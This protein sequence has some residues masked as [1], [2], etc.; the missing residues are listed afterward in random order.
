M[1]ARVGRRPRPLDGILSLSK[2]RAASRRGGRQRRIEPIDDPD[3]SEHRLV[4]DQ[5]QQPRLVAEVEVGGRLIHDEHP[6]LKRDGFSYF[7]RLLCR[8]RQ[9]SCRHPHVEVYVEFRQ[10]FFRILVH[11]PPAH[12]RT[13]ILVADEDVLG[14]VE[15]GETQRLL[16][17]QGNPEVQFGTSIV[18]NGGKS[19]LTMVAKGRTWSKK[20]GYQPYLFKED[21]MNSIRNIGED[22]KRQAEAK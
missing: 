4:T 2:I 3:V 12:D 10:D 8:E 16:V 9:P 20:R 5:R 11:L 21:F 17:D 6:H 13:P 7:D 1:P 19:I 18:E 22:I 14:N 15:V